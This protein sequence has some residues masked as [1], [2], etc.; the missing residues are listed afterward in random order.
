[1]Y[2]YVVSRWILVF[3][4]QVY[5]IKLGMNETS[6]IQAQINKSFPCCFWTT[7]MYLKSLWL[8]GQDMLH[9]DGIQFFLASC[10][11]T[12]GFTFT[13]VPGTACVQYTKTKDDGSS[14]RKKLCGRICLWC[15]N[16]FLWAD[17]WCR[18]PCVDWNWFP[19]SLNHMLLVFLFCP[20]MTDEWMSNCNATEMRHVQGIFYDN[21]LMFW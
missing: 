13:L 12:N 3:P 17:Q 6:N 11:V 1:M 7:C 8:K 9:V 18:L 10:L 4:W 2:L 16:M 20:N 15:Q 14:N 21:G 5:N 19:W